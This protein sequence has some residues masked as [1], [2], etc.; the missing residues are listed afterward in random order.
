MLK[1]SAHLD[2]MFTTLE[3]HKPH[4]DAGKKSVFGNVLIRM[5]ICRNSMQKCK[6]LRLHIDFCLFRSSTAVTSA[7][8]RRLSRFSWRSSAKRVRIS[9]LC[10]FAVWTPAKSE[11]IQI[12]SLSACEMILQTV[13]KL[14]EKRRH[15]TTC[16]YLRYRQLFGYLVEFL[17][18][19]QLCC[20]RGKAKRSLFL[21]VYLGIEEL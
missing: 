7:S 13:H 10:A 9:S 15:K 16:P 19:T 17:A 6:E 2:L 3:V 1:N 12:I 4:S 14:D 21:F 5:Y 8:N 20:L 18:V 11:W